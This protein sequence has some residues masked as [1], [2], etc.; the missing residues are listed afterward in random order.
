MN[1]FLYI[2]ASRASC[3]LQRKSSETRDVPAA[4]LR[5]ACAVLLLVTITCILALLSVNS[6]MILFHYLF[7]GFCC[8]QGPF[9]F[10]FRVVFNKEARDAMRYCCGKKRP[11][12]M[13]K[14]KPS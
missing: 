3:S 12:H 8:A 7:A 4:G 5:T 14:S 13:I 11:D 9:I 2:M 10:F 1:V 6:D